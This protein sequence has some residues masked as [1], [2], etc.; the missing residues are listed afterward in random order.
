M[1]YDKI[2]SLYAKG[3][4]GLEATDFTPNFETNH[5]YAILQYSSLRAY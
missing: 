2:L 1:D 3:I 4:V 5:A